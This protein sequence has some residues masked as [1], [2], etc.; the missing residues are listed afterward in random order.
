MEIIN[1][2]A[3]ADAVIVN[4][5]SFIDAAQEESVDTILDS[6]HVR[7]ARNRG[8]ALIVS[9]NQ[10]AFAIIDSLLLQLDKQLPLEL[11]DIRI[12]TLEHADAAD[13]AA[14]LQ[15]LLDAR[16]TQKATF[17]DGELNGP[18]SIFGADGWIVQKMN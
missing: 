9:G 2:A 7:E 13:V 10:K 14:A 16:V 1:D 11:R 12:V 6:A 18:T 3:S 15:R 4:T 17:I 5:C 8:Q